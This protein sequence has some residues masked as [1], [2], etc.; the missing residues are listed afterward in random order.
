[1][2]PKKIRN[3]FPIFAHHTNPPLIFLDSGASAQK[4]AQVIDTMATFYRTQ[5][6]NIHRGLYQLGEEATLAFECTRG[7]V[8]ELIN[9][10]H[11]EVVFTK[12]T[13][14]SINFVA[15]AWAMNHLKA[16]DEIILTHA[17][18]HANL[19]PWQQVAKKTGALI[20]FIP[21]NTQTFLLEPDTS[22]ITARTKLVAVTLCSNVLGNIWPD[23]SLENFVQKARSI[24]ARILFDGAHA[25]GHMPIDVKKLSA[26][27]LAFSGHKMLGPSGIGVLYISRELH[28]DVEPYQ[29]GGSMIYEASYESATWADAPA[30]FEAGTPPIVSAIGLGATIDYL[31]KNIQY[32]ALKKH[33]NNLTYQLLEGLRAI[34]SVKIYGNQEQL[35]RDGHLVCFAVQ[36]IHGHDIAAYLAT[37]NIALRAGHHCAQPL[38]KLLGVDALVRPSFAAY[39]IPDEID[40]LL[41][42]LPQAINH[43]KKYN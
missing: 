26:D 3:D 42:V 21:L 5:Y 33:Y 29:F 1:M 22:L 31:K 2:D 12:G 14:E 23:N 8:A 37:H 10:H 34:P 41:E 20:K 32:D 40:A 38:I 13:T 9:A 19:L 15:T 4:P 27:F 35:L 18:H 25:I 43:L 7:Q 28:D 11:N 16:G 39:T 24:G 6:A 30:K 17:E 36:D